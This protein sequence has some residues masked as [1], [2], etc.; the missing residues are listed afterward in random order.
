M[1]RYWQQI[2]VPEMGLQGQQK[3]KDARVLIAGAGGLGTPV[4]TYLAAAGVGSI[5]LIDGDV[6][7]VSNLHRQFHFSEKESGLP[8]VTVLAKRLIEQNP[9]V[10]VHIIESYIDDSNAASVIGSYDVVCDCT[11]NSSAR[12]II[13]NACRSVSK[14]LVYAAV[15]GWEGYITVLHH[16]KK[17]SLENIFSIHELE[18]TVLLDC[19]NFGIINT[20]CGISGCIQAN[21]ALKIIAGIHS[22]LDGSILCFNS[23]GP[24]FKNFVLQ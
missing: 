18:D 8:K 15:K 20:T 3:I 11:D 19:A 17:K 22:E 23:L 16:T 24:V 1:Q 21:E 4:A 7:N 2:T 9:E 6:I 12:I 14:P 13:N 10:S 5:G